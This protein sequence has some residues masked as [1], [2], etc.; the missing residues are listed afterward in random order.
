M[1]LFD[2]IDKIPYSVLI[3]I[4]LVLG[5][6]PFFPVPH[7]YEKL[8]MLI[9]GILKKP[10]DIFDLFLHSAPILILILKIARDALKNRP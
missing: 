4:A 5:L 2:I 3:V 8:V 10:I 6:A 7:L 9:K 1:K